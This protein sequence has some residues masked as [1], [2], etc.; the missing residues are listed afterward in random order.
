[1]SA[2]ELTARSVT[3]AKLQKYLGMQFLHSIV[4]AV[5][6]RLDRMERAVQSS[7]VFVESPR[8]QHS[9]DS[10][11]CIRVCAAASGASDTD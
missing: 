11:K 4:C 3:I 1:M 7:R 9:F 2:R 6:E 5:K 8:D 10:I